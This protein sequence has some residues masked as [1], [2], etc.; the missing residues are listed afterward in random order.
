ML[1]IVFSDILEGLLSVSFYSIKKDKYAA[2]SQTHRTFAS[3][4]DSYESTISSIH[5]FIIN[6]RIAAFLI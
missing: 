5:L 1:E 3:F 4:P 6:S 2:V